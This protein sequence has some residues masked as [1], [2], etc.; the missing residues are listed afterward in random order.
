MSEPMNE[1]TG[2]EQSGKEQPGASQVRFFDNLLSAMRKGAEDAKIAAERA[3][4]KVKAAAAQA[5]YWAEYGISFATSFT[6]TLAGEITPEPLKN[7]W[8][9][10]VRAGKEAALRW[11][12]EMRQGKAQSANSEPKLLAGPDAAGL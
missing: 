5:D 9:T 4:P 11:A 1:T 3:L 12:T 2:Q 6:A 8:R 7:G 10:G